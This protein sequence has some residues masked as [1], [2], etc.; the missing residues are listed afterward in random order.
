[1]VLSSSRSLLASALAAI[2]A[3]LALAAGSARA[4][5]VVAIRGGGDGHGIGLSQ[6][7]AAGYA[8]HGRGYEW[9][10]HHYYQ[11]T[12][13]GQVDPSQDVRVLISGS[14]EPTVS[15][16]IDAPGQSLSATQ[17]LNPSTAYTVRPNGDGTLTLLYH[18]R[19]KI[20]S[21]GP[22]SAP[23]TLAGVN[24]LDLAG[25][26]GYDGTLTFRPAGATN[27]Q[28]VE[29][30]GL[31]SYVSGVVADESPSN[32][33]AGALEAQAVAARTYA[34]T[35]HVGNPNYDLYPDTRSQMYGGIRAQTSAT[36]S[37]VAATS[38]QVVTYRGAPVVTYFS[39]SSGGHTESIQNEW[40]GFKPEPWLVGVRDPYDGAE[41]NPNH[42]WTG[43]LA[44]PAAEAKLAGWLRG[45]GSLVGIRT[46]QHGVSPRVLTAQIVGTKGTLNVS[47]LA[48]QRTLGLMSTDMRF[49]TVTTFP[50]SGR[51]PGSRLADA[52]GVST[53]VTGLTPLVDS[54]LAGALRSVHGTIYPA[55]AGAPL[56]VQRLTHGRWRQAI[57]G[58]VDAGSR[59]DLALPGPG[60][61]RIVFAGID[62]P[63]VKA[64]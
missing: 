50:G 58:R 10:L 5:G 59:Y 3:I 19:K 62:G 61:Y 21:L 32:W 40:P 13:L 42:H 49:T 31:D 12:G 27:V 33:P 57:R 47:G 24:S 56:T 1:M 26:G 2:A 34:I 60:T 20:K 44:L 63:A 7:G 52:S 36:D 9:I 29:T 4:A 14:G 8:L 54:L 28:T 43:T 35:D 23:L 48:L 6:Y 37:A 53:A 30:V 25:L 38:G 51:P 55:R 15:G 41:G 17:N 18:G 11:H 64:R 39:S 46:V 45:R 22:F 16:V